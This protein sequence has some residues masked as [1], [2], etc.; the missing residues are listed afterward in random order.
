MVDIKTKERYL[1]ED[2]HLNTYQDGKTSGMWMHRYVTVCL[3]NSTRLRNLIKWLQAKPQRA[4]KL[5]ILVIDDEADQASVNTRKMKEDLDEEEQ[6]RTAV[7][8]LIIDLI[9]GKDHGRCSVKG[10][11]SGD[12]LYQLYCYTLC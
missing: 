12:E 2:L 6:E 3:K 5:R 1:L 10:T 8:Q 11:F 9:N 7:N 4:A